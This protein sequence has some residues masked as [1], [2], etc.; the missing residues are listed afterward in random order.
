MTLK[1]ERLKRVKDAIDLRE[2]DRVPIVPISQ[3]YAILQA[4]YTMADILYDFDKA[5]EAFIKFA[6]DYEPDDLMGHEYIHVG[7]GPLLELMESTII[8]WA[9]APDN[10]ISK[11][12]IHQFVEF[13]VLQ[14]DEME[15]FSNDY[16]GWML[17]RALPRVS[18]LMAPLASWG[19]SSMGLMYTAN[20][21][22]LARA[23]S[24]PQ[25]R[26]MI[27]SLWKFNDISEGLNAKWAELDAKFDEMG[28]P[29]MYKGIATVPYDDY[30]DWYRG[31]I[32]GLQDLYNNEE[33]IVQFCK[34]RLAESLAFIEFQ[35]KLYPGKYIFMPLHKGMDGFMSDEFYRKYYWNDLQ[36][37]ILKIIDVGM[38][39]YIYTEGP[40]T[41]RLECLKDVPKGKVI[42]HFEEC[43]MAKAKKV[44]G[45]VAC[46]A[47]GFPVSLL[48][49]GTKQEVIDECKRL[50]DVC[51]PGGGYI[52]ETSC[53]FDD[54]KP[55]NVEAMVQTVKEY[56]KR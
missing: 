24:T 27:E 14:E 51:A 41:T 54:A 52:F 28:L 13:P 26:K 23:V 32:D 22:S 37:Q 40:Y 10:R 47:G 7:M 31:T 45:D 25:S 19:L 49:F 48:H 50:I 1:E 17:E 33:V 39:P 21:G 8:T 36:A 38:T 29:L 4:G 43:D 56:G 11:N 30:T 42:Y 34:K 12:S 20:A 16:T 5:A 3:T 55:E 18:G 46:I 6:R 35:A 2:P 53:G 9:G 44:L 15:L